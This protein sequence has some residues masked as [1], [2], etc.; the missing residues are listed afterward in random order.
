[1]GAQ[2][3]TLR[4]LVALC[5][6]HAAR[7]APTPAAPANDAAD[8]ADAL[9]DLTIDGAVVSLVAGTDAFGLAAFCDL[10]GLD[11]ANC[12]TLRYNFRLWEGRRAGARARAGLTG[13]EGP[14]GTGPDRPARPALFFSQHTCF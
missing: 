12:E 11:A 9:F 3:R 6:I 8:D 7:A 14:G 1:M 13:A 5:A 2:P 4:I 10:H